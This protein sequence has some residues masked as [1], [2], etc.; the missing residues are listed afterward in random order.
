M[1]ETK[2]YERTISIVSSTQS[3]EFDLDDLLLLKNLLD[4]NSYDMI[5]LFG[6]DAKKMK[7]YKHCLNLRKWVQSM[8]REILKK[9]SE[10][11]EEELKN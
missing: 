5:E 9:D 11:L 3:Y 6:E 1:S 7:E 8:M 4:S 2:N 10:D